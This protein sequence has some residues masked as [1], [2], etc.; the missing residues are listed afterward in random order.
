[1]IISVL[2]TR[3]LSMFR[4]YF[5]SC[6]LISLLFFVMFCF[7]DINKEI[8]PYQ[9]IIHYSFTFA[10]FFYVL[11]F[12]KCKQCDVLMLFCSTFIFQFLLAFLLKIC[13]VFF[14]TTPFGPSAI[15]SLGYFDYAKR[16]SAATVSWFVNYLGNYTVWGKIDDYGYLFYL[17]LLFQLFPSSSVPYIAIILN[18]L[19]ISIGAIFMYKSMVLINKRKKR[20]AYVVTSVFSSFLFFVNSSAV[21]LKEDLFICLIAISLYYLIRCAQ[22]HDLIS[23]SLF[24]VSTSLTLLF[25]ASITLIIVFSFFVYIVT[26]NNNKKLI[27]ILFLSSFIIMP[28]ILDFIF[29]NLFG[30]SLQHILD[31][32]NNRYEHTQ[33]VPVYKQMGDMLAAVLGPFPSF[34]SSNDTMFYTFASLIKMIFNLPVLLALYV[35]IKKFRYR[36]YPIAF[37]YIIGMIFLIISGTGLDLRYQIPFFISFL[38]LL[39]YSLNNIRVRKIYVC[40]Y[41]IA[42]VFI[43][44]LYNIMK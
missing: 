23:L 21:G 4:V 35:I 12:L 7:I 8:R 1:M 38:L 11:L 9:L 25:R 18:A 10:S 17:R 22:K 44:F 16:G 36:Y 19:Y 14:S 26:T 32:A 30:F 37:I 15:D 2:R 40:L 41:S 20:N 29:T 31:V 34:T 6:L 28:F 43:I 3:S 33:N 24:V 39:F 42:C 13:F 27:L 5:Y